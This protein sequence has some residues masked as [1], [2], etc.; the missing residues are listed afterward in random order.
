[1]ALDVAVD[2]AENEAT[3]PEDR[4]HLHHLADPKLMRKRGEL[5][6]WSQRHK[7]P[8]QNQVRSR[9]RQVYG[10]P[11]QIVLHIK[12]KQAWAG[13]KMRPKWISI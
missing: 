5:F 9:R 6:E 13:N 4:A 7:A 11:R 1:M 10:T 2:E 3:S 8:K 12:M